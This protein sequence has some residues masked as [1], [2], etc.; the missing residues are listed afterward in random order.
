MEVLVWLETA[1]DREQLPCSSGRR[2]ALQPRG[3]VREAFG[4]RQ[5]EHPLSELT[6]SEIS[7]CSSCRL[8]NVGGDYLDST[9]LS[10]EG[11]LRPF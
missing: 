3:G 6:L 11:A 10:P 5:E 9:S 1:G 8:P 2:E 7:G 4:S